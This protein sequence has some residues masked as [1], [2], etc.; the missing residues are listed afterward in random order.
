LDIKQIGHVW[1]IYSTAWT[2]QMLLV[3][4]LPPV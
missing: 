1:F 3:R 2:A 4:L